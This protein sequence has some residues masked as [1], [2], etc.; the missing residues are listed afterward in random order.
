[1]ITNGTKHSAAISRQFIVVVLHCCV[2]RQT[3][4]YD[5][6]IKLAVVIVVSQVQR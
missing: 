6:F 4:M 5:V 1:M 2:C 3:S